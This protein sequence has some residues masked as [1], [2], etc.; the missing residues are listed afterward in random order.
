MFAWFTTTTAIGLLVQALVA[1]LFVNQ[2]GKDTWVTVHGVVA[3]LSW[4]LALVTAVVAWVTLRAYRLAGVLVGGPV[5]C[6]PCL[7][8]ASGT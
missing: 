6:Q 2:D 8:Q 5:S 7:R 4:E 1:G 3:D